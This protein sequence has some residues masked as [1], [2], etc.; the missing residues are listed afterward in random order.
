[1][2][3]RTCGIF[4]CVRAAGATCIRCSLR[5]LFE[6]ELTMHHPGISCR[7]NAMT[8]LFLGEATQRVDIGIEVSLLAFHTFKRFESNQTSSQPG[9]MRKRQPG[10]R[11]RYF[12][13]SGQRWCK[14]RACRATKNRVLQRNVRPTRCTTRLWCL[15]EDDASR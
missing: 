10:A 7:G 11:P 9:A 2:F 14:C 8:W 5:P 1:V 4:L 12:R 15:Q 13:S 6:G 3:R